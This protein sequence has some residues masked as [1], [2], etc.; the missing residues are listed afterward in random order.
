[1]TNNTRGGR[2]Y[3]P[4]SSEDLISIRRSA[5]LTPAA[6]ARAAGAALEE[7][8]GWEAGLAVMPRVAAWLLALWLIYHT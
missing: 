2:Y 1:M 7:Y 5:R 4:P 8:L 6:A 3:S